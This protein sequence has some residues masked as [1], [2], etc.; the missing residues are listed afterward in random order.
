MSEN[1]FYDPNRITFEILAKQQF[2]TVV[3]GQRAF[4]NV[5]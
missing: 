4:E 2:R 3:F 5:Y 1:R